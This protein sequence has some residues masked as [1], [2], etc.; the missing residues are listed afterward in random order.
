MPRRAAP[1]RAPPPPRRAHAR[2]GVDAAHGD[3]AAVAE[4]VGEGDERLAARRLRLRE[5]AAGG[6][7]GGAWGTH[8]G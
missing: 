8:T 3:D 4:G 1:R 5:E 6:E 7:R 2:L